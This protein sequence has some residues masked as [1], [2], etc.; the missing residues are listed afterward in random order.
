M[1]ADRLFDWLVDGAPGITTPA[2][3]VTR[4]GEELVDE[5]IPVCR[6][7]A[8]VS[9]LHP[10][11]YGR[12]FSWNAGGATLIREAGNDLILSARFQAS[13]IWKVYRD[14]VEI[15]RRLL[16]P[17]TPRDFPVTIELDAEGYTDYVALP[18]MF[19]TGQ[20]H[21]ISFA[22]KHAEGFS[23]A[24]IAAMRRINR[25]LARLAEILALR[26]TAANLLSTYVGRN[27]G[28]RILAGRIRKGD[29]CLLYTSDAADE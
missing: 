20:G 5:G 14:K 21:A 17:A 18:M 25:P 7:T 27:A 6:I 3:V 22:T 16:D 11:V 8:F 4:I 2:D 29:I 15:R 9:T 19:T 10:D 1:G 23:D 26:R 24:Q 12:M 28:E 13:P